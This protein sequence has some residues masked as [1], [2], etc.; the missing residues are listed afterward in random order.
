[1]LLLYL[2]KLLLMSKFV[3]MAVSR[4]SLYKLSG[5]KGVNYVIKDIRLVS[6]V[7]EINKGYYRSISANTSLSSRQLIELAYEIGLI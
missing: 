5:F 4:S 2:A 1:M 3:S 6:S 7:S